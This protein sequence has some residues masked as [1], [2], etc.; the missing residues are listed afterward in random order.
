[1]PKN[2]TLSVIVPTYNCASLIGRHIASMQNWL[3]LADEIIV[4]DS[5]STDGTNE[6]IR[7]NLHHPN[8]KII[9]RQPGLYESWNQ[10]ITATSGKWI[11]I[12]TV[13]DV[14]SRQ[15]LEKLL[16]LGETHGVDVVISPQRFVDKDGIP[17]IEPTY[18]NAEIYQALKG[19]G[20]AI[21]PPSATHFYAFACGKP[22]A[23]LG[24]VASDL[25]NGNHLRSRPFSTEYGTHG[26]TAW[27]LRYA[28]ETSLC[29]LPKGGSDFCIHPKNSTPSEPV[30]ETL[31]RMYQ[32]ESAQNKMST[33][34][35]TYLFFLRKTSEF[36]L[37]KRACNKYSL[38]VKLGKTLAYLYF[39]SL[40]ALY[41]RKLRSQIESRIHF[42]TA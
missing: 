32:A 17:I 38:I 33:E 27:I 16:N 39:R 18:H 3:D 19:R 22:N 24:S 42:F 40:L 35:K 1:M 5:H 41:E 34:F 9:E 7:Q 20:I 21:L 8:L 14:I 37:K 26:D 11:Y 31:Q 30:G 15:H 2:Y 25:F 10:A 12:S 13:G 6:L 4:V 28:R 29:L 36:W 23:L